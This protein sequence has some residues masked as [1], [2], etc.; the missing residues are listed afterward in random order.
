VHGGFGGGVGE[1]VDERHALPINGSYVWEGKG[2]EEAEEGGREGGREGGKGEHPPTYIDDPSG[3]VGRG[4][5]FE[6]RQC[7]AGETEERRKVKRHDFVERLQEKEKTGEWITGITWTIA[8]CS[9]LSFLASPRTC[10]G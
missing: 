2:E 10:K 7:Q 1:V 8:L 4:S 6:K 9:S 3:V 5:C